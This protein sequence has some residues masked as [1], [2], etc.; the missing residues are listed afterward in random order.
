MNFDWDDL[1]YFL[2]V[3]EAGQLS[4]AGRRLRT[5]HVTVSRRIERLEHALG[6]R[7]FERSAQ[8]YTLT[9]A[10]ERLLSHAQ[11]MEREAEGVRA[12]V[13]GARA[14]PRGVVRLSTPEGFGTYFLAE[15]LARFAGENPA[16]L[17]EFMTIQQIVS[18]SRRE[19]DIQVALH[20]PASGPY[21]WE[22]IARY[23]LFLYASHDYLAS[24]GAP[25]TREA[26]ARH[27]LAGYIDDMIFTPGLDYLRDILPGMRA[28]YQS[29][30]IQAQLAAGL[31]GYGL[32]ILPNFIARRFPA[33]VPIM[34]E[35]VH[36]DRDY[37][38]IRHQENADV[39][40][41]RAVA[42][43]LREEAGGYEAVF[44]GAD[45]I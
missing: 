28:S 39:P 30:S 38:M 24:Q 45:A 5:S 10:G 14:A 13:A 43:F 11:A 3:A 2:A 34:P 9:V 16:L 17:L 22:R 6:L 37:W 29:S 1:Q 41:I 19:A 40:R 12:A 4:A 32:C 18:L 21:V 25:Q 7:L 20:P 26:I 8:G 42:D 33:L 35:A 36:L 44:R 15:R 23:R 27:P 31:A